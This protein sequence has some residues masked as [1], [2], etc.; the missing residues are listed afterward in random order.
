VL[1]EAV[2]HAVHRAAPAAV[3]AFNTAP[4][5]SADAVAVVAALLSRS[6]VPVCGHSMRQ[7]RLAKSE[8]RRSVV[9]PH[10]GM[11]GKRNIKLEHRSARVE[12]RPVRCCA[13]FTR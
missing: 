7:L 4:E 12:L 13:Y 3:I 9:M 11:M 2:V 5:V 8:D 6:D 1:F 10:Y